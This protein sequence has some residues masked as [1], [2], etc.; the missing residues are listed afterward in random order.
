MP[1]LAFDRLDAGIVQRMGDVLQRRPLPAQR[2]DDPRQALGPDT[3]SGLSGDALR[4]EVF[5]RHD[6]VSQY[7]AEWPFDQ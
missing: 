2:H 6:H 4:I 5:R 1:H 7:P 3:R